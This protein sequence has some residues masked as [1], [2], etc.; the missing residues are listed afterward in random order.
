MKKEKSKKKKKK[1]ANKKGNKYPGTTESSHQPCYC[2]CVQCD[3]G[4]HCQK[5]R[6]GCSVTYR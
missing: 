4:V 1:K 6:N 2:N 5:E 3:I